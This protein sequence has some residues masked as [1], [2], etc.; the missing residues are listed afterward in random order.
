VLASR[1]GRPKTIFKD[2]VCADV[3]NNSA[4]AQYGTFDG[5]AFVATTSHNDGKHTC[6]LS[7]VT[8]GEATTCSFLAL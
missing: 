6:M 3:P 7:T 8:S 4:N 2:L 1:S 5:K